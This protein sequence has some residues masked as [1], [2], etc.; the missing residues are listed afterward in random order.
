MRRI[1]LGLHET[2]DA[3]LEQLPPAAALPCLMA[4]ALG[5]SRDHFPIGTRRCRKLLVCIA[6]DKLFHH[7]ESSFPKEFLTRALH[8]S[9][10]QR[11]LSIIIGSRAGE[12]VCG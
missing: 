2:L 1:C 7:A 10:L 6:H 3:A 8:Q 5:P 11:F 4:A 9:P 12:G